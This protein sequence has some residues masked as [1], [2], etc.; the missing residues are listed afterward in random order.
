MKRSILIVDDEFGLA[1]LISELLGE[2]GYEA[3]IAINGR[4]ALERLRKTPADLVMLDVMMPVMTG[5]ETARAMK[6]EPALAGIPIIMMTS[7]AASL[8]TDNPRLYDAVLL[9][10]FSPQ[11]MFQTIEQLLGGGETTD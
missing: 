2:G 5:P 4:L 10:P 3:A 7:L 6:A 1:E 11:A 9:K 8:P